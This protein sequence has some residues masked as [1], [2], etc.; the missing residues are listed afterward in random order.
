M[1]RQQ[2]KKLVKELVVSRQLARLQELA[3]RDKRVVG[4]LCAL[5]YEPD[6]HFRWRAIEA[7]GSVA[8][9]VADTDLQSVRELVRRL[10]WLMNDESGGAGWHS[11]EAM[12]AIVV[13]VPPLLDTFGVLLGSYLR[14]DGLSRGA[15]WA[16]AALAKVRPGLFADRIDEL[17]V[18]LDSNDPF[19]RGYAVIAL[20]SIAGDTLAERTKNMRDDS[21]TLELYTRDTGEL[22]P[23]TVGALVRLLTPTGSDQRESVDVW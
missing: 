14:D 11:P 16:V 3:K 15:H 6:D 5:L 13:N 8:A 23:T 9:I 18:S 17:T 10:E 20:A 2:R 22:R 21:G 19:I 12:A 1:N 4:V 7:L